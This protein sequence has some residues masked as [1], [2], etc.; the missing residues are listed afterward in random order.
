MEL[1]IEFPCSQ[2]KDTGPFPDADE[3]IPNRY[4]IFL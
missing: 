4:N 2:Q 3:W 1:E